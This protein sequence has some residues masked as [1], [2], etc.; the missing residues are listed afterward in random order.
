V[1][2]NVLNVND[3]SA[4]KIIVQ[5]LRYNSAQKKDD[6]IKKK[7][8]V[9]MHFSYIHLHDQQSVVAHRW[10][11]ILDFFSTPAWALRQGI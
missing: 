7:L 5:K 11:T 8:H 1:Y 4:I 10:S 6:S 3:R 2:I 9:A